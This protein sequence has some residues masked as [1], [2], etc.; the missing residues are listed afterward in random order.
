M[1]A[2]VEPRI[3]IFVSGMRLPAPRSRAVALR[4]GAEFLVCGGLNGAG[5][6]TASITR[7]DLQ[8]R[9]VSALG[10]L[11]ERTQS[12]AGAVIG[13]NGFIFGGGA[14]TSGSSVER[15]G[16]NGASRALGDLL[17]GDRI[18]A[19]AVNVGGRI[20]IVGGGPAGSLDGRILASR[21]GH[22]F[23]VIGRLLVKV[24]YPAVATVG[25]IVYVI[26]GRTLTGDARAI[27]AIDPATG[28]V[29][30][31]G[32]LDR[33]LSH[34]VAAVVGGQLL[35]A[36]GRT[37]GLAQDRLLRLDVAS[38]AVKVVGRLPYKVSDMAVGVYGR[39]AYLIGGQGAHALATIIMVR[40]DP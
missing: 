20:I 2:P 31:I 37:S 17:P 11:R 24:R 18:G 39:T 36:G 25:G 14:P 6:A 27:Q 1:P 33:G 21:D 34:A 9:R 12:S 13:T 10:F 26:G 30:L 7:I 40:V 3:H 32:R 15:V 35:I 4:F 5:Q 8:A 16:P 28:T 22:T 23:K 38:G 29:R 19:A